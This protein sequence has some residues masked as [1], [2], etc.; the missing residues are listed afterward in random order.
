MSYQKLLQQMIELMVVVLILVGC[1]IPAT[2]PVPS[3]ATSIP[4]TVTPIP[5]S[6][7]PTPGPRVN[8]TTSGTIAR[9]EIWRGEIHLTGDITMANGATLTIEPGTVV[10]IASNGDDQHCCAGDF[11][12]EYTRS[13]NDPT[14]FGSWNMNAILIDG[15][16]GIIHAVGTSEKPIAF[17]P[18]GD[19]T[20]PAQWDGVYIERGT[21]QYTILLY[22]GHTVIQPLGKSGEVIE[23]AHNE[24]RY[25]LWAGID[26]H[27]TN[28]WIHNNIV[29]G[30]GHHGIGIHNDNVVVEN[31]IIMN[32]QT[33]VNLHQQDNA[34]VRNNLILDCTNGIAVNGTN[35]IITNNTVARVK[36]PPAGWYFQGQLIYPAFSAGGGIIGSAEGPET[37]VNNIIYGSFNWAIAYHG[38]E[39]TKGARVESNLYWNTKSPFG[40]PGQTIISRNNFNLDPQFVD[41][42]KQD[43]HLLPSS[44]AIDAGDPSIFD[45]DGS[46]SDLGAYGGMGGQGW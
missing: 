33:G 40:G 38:G 44:P 16:G 9:D 42:I 46:R 13:N 34:N 32:C 22:G 37:I 4:L 28:V 1:G 6:A 19:N 15:R 41:P 25:F 35:S 24:V 45:A 31:N 26:A 10:Y 21:I 2:A 5:S 14:R 8:A 18:E 17:R 20:S 27:T 36:G 11:D 30:G 29:E 43:F 12:D 23:I 3:T 39:P 7:T